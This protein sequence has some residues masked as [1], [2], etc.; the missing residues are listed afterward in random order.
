[1]R[2]SGGRGEEDKSVRN[3]IIRKK[4]NSM[5]EIKYYRSKIESAYH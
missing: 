5:V 4:I 3:Q 2:S 1:M